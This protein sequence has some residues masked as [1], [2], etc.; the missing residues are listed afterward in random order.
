MDE[1]QEGPFEAESAEDRHQDEYSQQV[2]KYAQNKPR[3]KKST[4]RELCLFLCLFVCS[5]ICLFVCSLICL[6]VCS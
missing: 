2:E 4:D 5:L 1:F 3:K 6:F